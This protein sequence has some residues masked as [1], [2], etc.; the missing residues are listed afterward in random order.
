VLEDGTVRAWEPAPLARSIF[1][2]VLLENV[3]DPADRA[4]VS[5]AIVDGADLSAGERDGL[6]E[7][8]RLVYELFSTSD[9]E[10]VDILLASLPGDLRAR[11]A[12]VSPSTYASDLRARMY[13]MHDV[14][15]AFV[16]FVESRRLAARLPESQRVY[17]E[18]SLFAHVV[19]SRSLETL[20]FLEEVG[21]LARHVYLV[22][23][24]LA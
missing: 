8:A 11:L 6:G 9:P 24:E 1:S 16:P 14:D 22:M 15:D 2:Y 19:P 23:L 17:T 5:R 18:F 10:R 7:R 21:K 3:E 20:A 4:L 13:L 12:A